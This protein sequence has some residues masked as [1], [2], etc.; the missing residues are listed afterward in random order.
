MPEHFSPEAVP[1]ELLELSKAIES[2]RNA[3][4][5]EQG[6]SKEKDLVRQVLHE[7]IF[8]GGGVPIIQ[9]SPTA[10]YLD[11][12]DDDS[13][14]EL[15]AYITR[16][17]ELGMKKTIALIK[18]ERPFLMDAFHD[19]LTDKLYDELKHNGLIT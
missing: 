6:V 17:P 10:H 15:N 11:A 7:E 8:S 18:Q 12:M 14:T 1:A 16:I 2:R 4:E 13:L 3:I 19:A 5:T 9:S